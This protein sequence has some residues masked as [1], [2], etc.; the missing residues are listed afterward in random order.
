MDYLCLPPGD[1]VTSLHVGTC[2]RAFQPNIYIIGRKERPAPTLFQKCPGKQREKTANTSIGCFFIAKRK[3]SLFSSSASD[4]LGRYHFFLAM[5][6]LRR[7]HLN[8]PVG[9]R[10]EDEAVDFLKRNHFTI[11]ERN[12][13]NRAGRSIG[14]I[15]II[16]KEGG[17]IV[18][19]EVKTRSSADYGQPEEFVDLA[20]ARMIFAAAEE[21]I[22]STDW[23]GHVRFDVI[24]VK[25]GTQPE[26]VHFEDAIN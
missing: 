8:H 21:F 20:K 12:W 11:L 10:G 6:F 14:E 16:A 19:I 5:S 17:D 22:F 2:S 9:E 7:F 26:I 24:S 4:I 3:E 23:Q 13:K 25:L 15:D 1:A 18:F